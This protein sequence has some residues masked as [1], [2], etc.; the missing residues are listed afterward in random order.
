LLNTRCNVLSVSTT[1]W[2]WICL[3]ELMRSAHCRSIRRWTLNGYMALIGSTSLTRS[4]VRISLRG[5][6]VLSV[7]EV[8]ETWKVPSEAA[9]WLLKLRRVFQCS[10]SPAISSPRSVEH[11]QSAAHLDVAYSPS[12]GRQD[13]PPKTPK[14]VMVELGHSH[15]QNRPLSNAQR[16]QAE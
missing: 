11:S 6:C 16:H 3:S 9:N 10:A 4:Y 7:N 5:I 1:I 12:V 13:A 2:P 8:A 15:F 14:P